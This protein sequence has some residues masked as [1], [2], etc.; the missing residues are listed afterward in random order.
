MVVFILLLQEVPKYFRAVVI[1]WFLKGECVLLSFNV[2]SAIFIWHR[3][4]SKAWEIVQM[5]SALELGDYY[6]C[7]F[8]RHIVDSLY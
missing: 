3:D 8:G 1:L 6:R 4:G 2:D 5:C 7:V